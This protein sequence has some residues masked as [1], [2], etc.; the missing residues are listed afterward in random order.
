MSFLSGLSTGV[1]DAGRGLE[2]LF[3]LGGMEIARNNGGKFGNKFFNVLDKGVGSNFAAGAAGGGSILGA[4]GLGAFGGASA[5]GAGA[6]GG[7]SAMAPYMPASTPVMGQAGSTLGAG[8]S[9]PM[10]LAPAYG[11]ATGA[12]AGSPFT[13]AA[14]SATSQALNYMR[15]GQQG[16]GYKPP[17]NNQANMLQKIYQMFPGIKPGSAMGQGMNVGGMNG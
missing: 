15:M 3:T 16:G 11:S 7:A 14:P 2:D 8:M 9:S 5:G 10:N 12:A 6:G 13:A 4:Q 17:A 1:S